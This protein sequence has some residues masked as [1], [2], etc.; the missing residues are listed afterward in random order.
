[1]KPF[2]RE[3]DDDLFPWGYY[4]PDEAECAIR[5]IVILFAIVMR[6]DN[7]IM[8]SEALVA[9]EYFD[10]RFKGSNYMSAF[11]TDK[12]VLRSLLKKYLK[13]KLPTFRD[14]ALDVVRAGTPYEAR[15]E[16]LEYLFKTAYASEGICDAEMVK[17]REIAQ[18]LLIK[19]WD[20]L[21][22]EY[23]YEFRRRESADRQKEN[24]RL[25]QLSESIMQ[26]A[27]LTL[28]VASDATDDEVRKAY[29][30]IVKVCHPDKLTEKAGSK[31]WEEKVVRFRHTVE[32]YHMV[33]DVRNIS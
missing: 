6:R 33:C 1:M 11:S 13:G 28:G 17:L 24:Q 23:K 2:R 15:L 8:A 14:C 21:S 27:Y 32:A 7:E 18:F 16:L 29:R 19:E 5:A 30:E 26:Q 3:S 25:N 4:S 31:E 9:H 12:K 10:K 22:L 20:L